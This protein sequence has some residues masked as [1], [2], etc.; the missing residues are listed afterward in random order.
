MAKVHQPCGTRTEQCADTRAIR[1]LNPDLSKSR[2]AG[3][4]CAELFDGQGRLVDNDIDGAMVGQCRSPSAQRLLL[5]PRPRQ[6]S[7][8]T[9][10]CHNR[11]QPYNG[12]E[13]T[14]GAEHGSSRK[15]GRRVQARVRP[16]RN[17][18]TV[19]SGGE[20]FKESPHQ[21]RS[22]GPKSPRQR[23]ASGGHEAG[24]DGTEERDELATTIRKATKR[25][26]SN[27]A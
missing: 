14:A 4:E 3:P 13:A 6:T 23:Y 20:D 2:Q 18:V 17:D 19:G 12:C 1:T 24:R 27:Q 10:C 22:R 15:Q 8:H 9:S 26:P 5:H 7:G 25:D 11:R 16:G 21:I